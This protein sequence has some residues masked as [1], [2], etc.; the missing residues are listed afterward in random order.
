MREIR[1]HDCLMGEGEFVWLPSCVEPAEAW[2]GYGPT[3][4]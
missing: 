3:S 2:R 4:A 1:V